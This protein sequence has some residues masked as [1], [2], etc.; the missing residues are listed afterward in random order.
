LASDEERL[1]RFLDLSGLDPTTI[2]DAS[3][4]PG[5]LAGVLDHLAS[6]E[7]LLL[8]FAEASERRPEAVMAARRVLSPSEFEG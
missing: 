5:F 2:R 7:E 1:Q 6:H 8:A 3:G 4:E